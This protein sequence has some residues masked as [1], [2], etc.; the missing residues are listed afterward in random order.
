MSFD[1]EDWDQ[2]CNEIGDGADRWLD[3]IEDLIVESNDYDAVMS[4]AGGPL[5]AVF[6]VGG[7]PLERRAIDWAQ[8]DAKRVAALFR[9]LSLGL[10]SKGQGDGE[11]LAVRAL[12]LN[13]V[14]DACARQV[15]QPPNTFSWDLW[16]VDLAVQMTESEPQFIWEL[17]QLVV[18]R[19]PPENLG[20][21]GAGLLEDFCLSAS[22][23]YIDR[24][25]K[26][27]AEDVS[28]KAALG[29]VWP[30]RD[31][32]PRATYARI[33]KAAGNAGS[34]YN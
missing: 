28:F 3:V 16:T 8:S 14:A 1:V 6:K 18:A 2:L 11:L 21:V 13:I 7:A 20:Q 15:V 30:G 26:R 12:D 25:E 4:V 24:I 33:R 17:I 29:R 31:T 34:P 19:V 23:Q 9:G 22:E 27:A 5:P 10:M 32:I